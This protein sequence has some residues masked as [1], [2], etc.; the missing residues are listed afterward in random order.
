MPKPLSLCLDFFGTR[1]SK[2]MCC[3]ALPGGQ[4]GLGL[5]STGSLLWQ[6]RGNT[7]CQLWVSSD[8]CLIAYRP[9]GAT[10][11]TLHRAGRVLEVPSGKPL[12]VLDKDE[13]EIGT[14][15]LRIHV[16]GTASEITGPSEYI[17]GS[18]VLGGI[19]SA[20]AAAALALTGGVGLP[21]CGPGGQQ[22]PTKPIEIRDKPPKPPD[23]YDPGEKRENLPPPV[24]IRDDPP[25]P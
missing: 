3:V 25:K 18:G 10:G 15:R 7:A 1:G 4:P 13:L 19:V 12:V 22:G 2:F 20:T 8:K 21:G 14:Q 24:E 17:P 23:L 5:D 6:D 11:F 9:E 16:H